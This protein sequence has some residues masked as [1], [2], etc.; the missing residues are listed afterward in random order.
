MGPRKLDV[1]FPSP[2]LKSAVTYIQILVYHS[3][4]IQ[5]NVSQLQSFRDQCI[6][7]HAQPIP[8]PIRDIFQ[9]SKL[10]LIGLFY[11][12]SVKKTYELWLRALE[13]DTAGGI[14]CTFI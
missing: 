7:T 5:T 3:T 12:V 10:K 14:G 4:F 1:I 6:K 9:I 2:N 11:Y 8:R 13:N